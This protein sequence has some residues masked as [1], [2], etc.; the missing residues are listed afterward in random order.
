MTA[1]KAANAPRATR[2]G[3]LKIPSKDPTQ[4]NTTTEGTHTNYYKDRVNT[5][6]LVATLF[7]TVTFTAGFTIPGG[8][9]NSKEDQGIATMLQR[10]AFHVFIFSDTIAM[11][12]SILVAVCLIW[13]QL[14]DLN[15]V[16]TA[17]QL[18]IPLLGVSLV[19]MSLA[20]T[21][22]VYLVVSNLNWLASSVLIMGTVFLFAHLTIFLPLCFPFSSTNR[23]LR[24]I[25][26]YPLHLFMFLTLNSEDNNGV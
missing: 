23:I 16:L 18:A 3:T 10:R 22:A 25:C 1:L 15:L 8:Y 11:Y 4:L 2:T 19:M 26:Y 7:A 20:F 24:Y 9:N 6:L 5:L 21:A 17:L 12:S 13:A 14:G